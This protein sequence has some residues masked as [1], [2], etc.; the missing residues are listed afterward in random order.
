LVIEPQ[1]T[2]L[3]T[4][5]LVVEDV[6]V[7]ANYLEACSAYFTFIKTL[8]TRIPDTRVMLLQKINMLLHGKFT[9]LVR[10]HVLEASLPC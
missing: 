2:I 10:V 8:Q 7:D 4:S 3:P 9:C 6:E 5:E 1:N